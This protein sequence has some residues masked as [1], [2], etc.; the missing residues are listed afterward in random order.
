MKSVT[1]PDHPMF[2]ML[3]R[4]LFQHGQIQKVVEISPASKGRIQVAT[5]E[6]QHADRV[7]IEIYMTH[8]ANEASPG[9]YT[10]RWMI[11]VLPAH[12]YK[13]LEIQNRSAKYSILPQ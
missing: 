8:V 13:I 3:Q 9:I 11:E 7:V 12:K 10:G 6:S 1:P 5:E 4:P 2:Q